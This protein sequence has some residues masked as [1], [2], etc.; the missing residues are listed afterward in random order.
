MACVES[1]RKLNSLGSLAL[2]AFVSRHAHQDWIAFSLDFNKAHKRVKIH[3]SEQVATQRADVTLFLAVRKRSWEQ[4]L[5]DP[6]SPRSLFLL[7]RCALCVSSFLCVASRWKLLTLGNFWVGGLLADSLSAVRLN[8]N[9][10]CNLLMYFYVMTLQWIC[11][12]NFVSV[13]Q[14]GVFW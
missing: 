8:A 9:V 14:L 7:L 12:P 6:S 5:G 2:G 10:L 11:L 3:P 13:F 4:L 1:E